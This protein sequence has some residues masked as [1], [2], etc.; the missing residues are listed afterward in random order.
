MKISQSDHD[1]DATNPAIKVPTGTDTGKKL[2]Q[3]KSIPQSKQQAQKTLKRRRGWLSFYQSLV[4]ALEALRANK[5]RSLLTSLG[6]IIGVGAVIMMISTSESNAAAIN[7]RLSNL[8]PNEL[9]IRSGSASVGGVRQGQGTSQSITQADA[10]AL[11]GISHVT[12]VSPIVGASGQIVFQGQ[13]WSSTAQGVYPAFQQLGSWQMQEGN[14]FT[15]DD[16]QSQSTVAVIGQTVATNLFTVQGVDPVGQQIRIRNVPFTIVGVLAPK[17]SSGGFNDPDDVVYVPFTTAQQ[18]LSGTSGSISIDVLVDDQ[19][20]LSDTQAAIEQTLEQRHN[21][22]NSANDDFTI[23]DQA[24]VL[25]TAQAT[26][27]ALTTLL[28]SVAA[29]SLLVGGIGIMN[30]MLVSV[31]ERTRE[32]GI[33]IAIGARPSDVMTQFLIEAL[34]LSALGGLVGVILGIG[35]AY[36]SSLVSSSSFVLSPLAVM[37]AFGFSALIGIVFGF[38]PARSAARLDPIV[39]LRSE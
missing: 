27:Q 6:I 31:T 22:T 38:Y 29:I 12:A 4:S 1:I 21:I 33:R 24:Q 10:D 26:S 37:L 20:N 13:N 5:L 25:A 14:F 17:G 32:I 35:G 11:A 36:I 23:Q 18:R 16:L 2:K 3:A 8:N 30:I 39:A 15:Q 34:V 7:A 19:S 28:I 9:V